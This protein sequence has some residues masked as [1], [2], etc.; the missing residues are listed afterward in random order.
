MSVLWKVILCQQKLVVYIVFTPGNADLCAAPEARVINFYPSITETIPP[1]YPGLRQE[2]GKLETLMW[3]QHKGRSA[4][5]PVL[6]EANDRWSSRLESFA[7]HQSYYCQDTHSWME[8][9]PSPHRDL[10]ILQEPGCPRPVISL[11]HEPMNHST[12][13]YSLQPYIRRYMIHCCQEYN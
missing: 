4:P 1:T 2:F 3:R 9:L 10:W 6:P 5:T 11:Y 7:C 8:L 12:P 13:A